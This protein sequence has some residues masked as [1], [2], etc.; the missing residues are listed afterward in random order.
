LSFYRNEDHL[1]HDLE[2]SKGLKRIK[3]KLNRK[4][5]SAMLHSPIHNTTKA[6]SRQKKR[7][8]Q[9]YLPFF[10]LDAKEPKNQGPHDRSA[11]W[12]GPP[13]HIAFSIQINLY[14]KEFMHC[15]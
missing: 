2:R 7:S 11:H 9:F 14:E 4:R 1:N 15:A 12:S 5:A 6:Q 3:Q 10:C 8:I 13:P